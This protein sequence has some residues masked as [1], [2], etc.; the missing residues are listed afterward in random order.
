MLAA[1]VPTSEATEDLAEVEPDVVVSAARAPDD[2][3]RFLRKH[4]RAITLRDPA[5]CRDAGNETHLATVRPL[6]VDLV[7][8]PIRP[9]REL[10]SYVVDRSQKY[11]LPLNCRIAVLPDRGVYDVVVLLAVVQ[12]VAVAAQ[13]HDVADVVEEAKRLTVDEPCGG[14]DAADR[15]AGQLAAPRP[16]DYVSH[17]K[18]AL[19]AASQARPAEQPERRFA[20]ILRSGRTRQ[21]GHRAWTLAA[22][23]ELARCFLTTVFRR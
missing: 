18:R 9:C 22:L 2:D 8:A 14:L 17:L 10:G 21:R 5:Q 23:S 16:V 4:A 6:S 12:A 15:C 3:G 19:G 20:Q 7:L 11:V 1:G 13:R